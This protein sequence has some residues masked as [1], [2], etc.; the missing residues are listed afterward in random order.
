[1]TEPLVTG[2]PVGNIDAQEE[3]Y[4]E[5]SP[6]I[7]FQDA[8]A[9]ELN[10]PDA[11][12]YYWNLSGTA[13]YPVNRI[14]CN[15]NVSLSEG[16]TINQIRCDTVGDKGTI[17]RRDYIELAFDFSSLFP[18]SIAVDLLKF[19]GSVSSSTGFEKAGIGKINNNKYFHAYL[20][21][22]YDTDAGDYVAMT[23]HRCQFVDAFTIGMN[24]GEPWVVSGMKLRA[25]ADETM[26]ADQLFATVIRFD[27]SALP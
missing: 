6:Y 17:Q 21:K 11:D 5:G 25:Y 24:G 1:M 15:M 10:N 12:G 16:L 8:T 14:G 20:P 4:V 2:A 13:T 18:L 3:I 27:P 23:F 22:V 7:Y 19:G 26:P 9:D